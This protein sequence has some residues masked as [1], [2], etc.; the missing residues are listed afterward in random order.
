MTLRSSLKDFF[1]GLGIPLAYLGGILGF[2][3]V[4]PL[5]IVLYTLAFALGAVW[6]SEKV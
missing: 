4:T 3:L 2:G 5:P 6:I 1:L